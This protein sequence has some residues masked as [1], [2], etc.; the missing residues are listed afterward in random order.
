M[1]TLEKNPIVKKPK[2]IIRI[3]DA[4][5]TL[6]LFLIFFTFPL[7]FLN[8]TYQGIIFEKQILFYSLT[9]LA[10]V[11]WAVKSVITG[12]FKI[13]RTPL[14]IPIIFFWLAYFLST[15]FSVDRW[16]SLFGFFGDPSR[17]FLNISAIVILHY[18]IFSNL[19]F[20]RIAMILIGLVFSGFIFSL[21]TFLSVFGI[22]FLPDKIS[23]M[24]PLVLSGS[25][26][27]AGVILS[28]MIIIFITFIFLIQKIDDLNGKFRNLLTFFIVI[29]L[30]I[31]II[32]LIALYN[33]IPWVSFLIGFGIFLIYIL[34]RI[35][36]PN[37]N[38]TWLPMIVFTLMMIILMIGP[39]SIA[40]INLPMEISPS[41][42][43]STQIIKGVLSDKFILGSGP[44]T[45]G[46]DFSFYRPQDFND[47]YFY[48]LRFYHGMG[49]LG[50]G[51]ATL[52]L[53][54]TLTILLLTVTYLSVSFYHLSR[55]KE[56]NKILS[57]GLITGVV[58]IFIYAFTSQ[59]EG[60][61]LIWGLSLSSLA[62]AVLVFESD[63]NEKYLVLNLKTSPKYALTLA[64]M[65]MVIAVGVAYLFVF[66]SKT[67]MA[68]IYAGSAVRE[69]RSS[70]EGTITNLAK[71]INFY[72]Q[73]GRYYTRISQEYMILANN[74][75]LKKKEE[76]DLKKIQ[77][78]INNAVLTGAKSK[79]LMKNDVST[80][81]SLA[82]IYEN[83]GSYMEN[84]LSL[85]QDTYKQAQSLE[86]HNPNYLIKLGQIKIAQASI[87][88]DDN[89]KKKL[90]GEA[91]EL[92]EKSINEKKDFAVGYYQLALTQEALGEKDEAI[93]NISQAFQLENSNLTYAF[94]VARM[95]QER[96]T[97][98]DNKIAENLF[99]QI[100]GVNDK[101]I[102]THFN[103]G[104]LYEKMKKNNDAIDEY[105]KVLALLVESSPE[106]QAEANE[107]R[108]RIEKMIE[109][110]EKG[111][112][113]TPE[114]LGLVQ[115][116]EN[117]EAPPVSQPENAQAPETFLE[118]P[119]IAPENN[120]IDIK[121]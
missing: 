37:E 103:L 30:I 77:I 7:F 65:F 99:K 9:F 20:R 110:L 90:I 25:L 57:L 86:P 120:N 55:E 8:I 5:I 52:G 98:E 15:I 50:E 10:I 69:E 22:R 62:L 100:L 63:A 56:K 45:Y 51:V 73:E 84:S 33:F 14:D 104:L 39:M 88:K 46:Y 121:Q 23:A 3:C 11:S 81:E 29:S 95:Y 112:E 107:S 93:K 42:N 38:W 102:N 41:Y 85:A 97:D 40:Q 74:E 4:L 17:G 75:M 76:R 119:I 61:I 96:G 91:K 87:V 109:N 48:N 78:Y 68:D 67:L 108:E 26:S 34:S 71:A 116:S 101:E 92:F 82:Q 21:W 32:L 111:I 115:A 64:F 12:E 59:I 118:Q 47:N 113:N 80:V 60:T 105:K 89:E 35:V 18:L 117:T 70:E 114:N 58:I 28:V 72:P 53:L 24:T 36:R 13:R 106:N 94:S 31:N 43:I 83:T 16:H 6:C 79:D 19:N 44:G 54:G 2:I 66:I 1:E 27:S 49:I